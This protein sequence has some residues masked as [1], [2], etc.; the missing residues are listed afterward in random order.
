[1]GVKALPARGHVLLWVVVCAMSIAAHPA[2]AQSYTVLHGFENPPQ[3]PYGDLLLGTD[4][5][6][7][8]TTFFGGT[9][10]YG[11]I[12]KITPAGALTTL[13]SFAGTDR[14]EPYAGLIQ[15][16]DGNFFGTTYEGG[17]S[18]QGTIFKITPA[19]VLTT[20]YSFGGSDG[21]N[22][23]AGLIQGT[24][25]DFYGTTVWGGASDYGT[26]FKITPAG[27]LTTLYSFAG[28]D[29]AE[30][31][32]GVIQG[33]DGNFF[34]TT[35]E[36]GTS[37]R[38]TIFKITPAGVLTTLH[39]FVGSDGA[40]PW[41]ALARG[42]DGNFYGTTLQGGAGGRGTVFKITPA[43]T[44]TT[45]YSFAEIDGQY[46]SGGL[47]MGTDLNFYG[48]TRGGGPGGQGTVFKI[49]PAGALTT[50]H[51]FIGSDG[52]EPWGSLV[53]GTDGDFYGLTNRGGA[54]G[55]GTVF[56]MTL[57]GA[58]TTLHSFAGNRSEG[59][60]PY[61]S[62]VV[63]P[64]G[65]FYGTTFEGGARN[66]GTVFQITPSGTLATLYSFAGSDGANPYAGLIQ[67]TDGNSYG[68]TSRGGAG[69]FGTV[70]Q[71]T[72]AGVLTTLHSFS[73][74]DGTVPVGGVVQG[75]DGSFY[76]TTVSGGPSDKGTIFK[77]TPAGA[78]TTLYS[79]TGGDA[80][81]CCDPWYPQAGLVQGTD[82]NLYGTTSGGGTRDESTGFF[83]DEGTIFTIEPAGALTMTMLYSFVW[84]DG[85]EPYAGLIQ[86]TDGDFY[87]TTAWGGA[88]SK[89]T[90]FKITP[91]G[92]LTTLYSFAGSD[93]RHP[94]AGLVQ[95]T[96]GSFFGTTGGGGLS[97]K[98]TIFKITSAGA[99]TTLH[100]FVG[101]DGSN[102]YAGLIQGTDGNFY[103][104]TTRGGPLG[105]GVVFRL[106]PG[107]SPTVAGVS[108]ANGPV[109][110]G[111]IVKVSGMGFQPGATVSFGA[112]A[113][114]DVTYVSA[115]TIDAVTPVHA[116][117]EVAVTVT[118]PDLLAGSLPSAYTYTCSW[119]PTALNGGPCCV[120]GTISLSTP[121]VSGATYSWTG[122]NGFASALQNPTIAS[123]T[124]ANAGTYSVTVTVAGCASAAGDTTVVVNPLPA[125]PSVTAPASV[126]AGSPN[127][128]ASVA[129][130]A[131]STYAWL[132][133]NGTITAGQGTNQVTFTAGAA[134]TPLT[135]SVTEAISAGC[136]SAPGN[137][138]VTV[139]PAGLAFYFLPPCR[140]LDTR[141]PAGPLGG[142]ALGPLATRTFDV[143]TSACGIPAGAIAISANLT[144]TNVKDRGELVAFPSDV[145]RP[146]TSSLSFRAG[147]T[148]ANNAIISLSKSSAT[149]SIFN[150]SAAAVDFILDVNGFFQ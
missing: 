10:D 145:A 140:V 115:T 146:D 33:T 3:R 98:G 90:I 82:G 13:Y 23:R 7:Y 45:L 117:G 6:F 125:A 79:F 87:G 32:A 28:R 26:I 74:P 76:G 60:F 48:T 53:P 2:A 65:N 51:S 70:F 122:P 78:L 129:A 142:P 134:G 85:G 88:S 147:R 95:G 50:L 106:T 92:A 35:Y 109:S 37:S 119:T 77:V 40:N 41:A 113:S 97:D 15:G 27:A 138:T 126:V 14:A 93:G 102:P 9:S 58:L 101:S 81:P 12:F 8:G 38:G 17:A 121:T 66:V 110:G 34:G 22:P 46:P 123:A 131:G 63:G 86:G 150:S 16:T 31:H 71:M 29:G 96:D 105:G 130:H 118:N 20:L 99:L 80:E 136:V 43:G 139:A 36:G 137:A 18:S 42:S 62:L 103:G 143:A 100:S 30:P 124:A 44:L 84:S 64:D 69:S 94:Q 116:A 144:V 132:I 21:A 54:G 73:G 56:K 149:F 107:P 141:N 135:L 61:A 128:T 55:Q 72:P 112:A 4:G 5:N 39:S 127:G 47:L 114:A 120:G 59:W 24:D 83:A 68:T 91:A 1:M 25:G 19:G 89:G 67:G 108:P 133:T 57:A 11:T 75:T 49:T 111:T 52:A 104:T 148:R